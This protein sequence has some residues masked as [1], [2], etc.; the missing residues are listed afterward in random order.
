MTTTPTPE[1]VLALPLDPA[2]HEGRERTIR[3]YLIALLSTLWR[4]GSDFSS[5]RPLGMSDWQWEIYAVLVKAG[6][7]TG[8]FDKLGDLDDCD[9]R[10]ADDLIAGA[11]ASLIAF[12]APTPVEIT[13]TPQT[14]LR[15]LLAEIVEHDMDYVTRYPLV[16]RAVTFALD[17][18]Y[19]AGVRID[20]KE[21]D[22]PVVYIELPTG[23][24][25]WHMP[26]YANAFDGH[27][28]PEKFRRI[29]EY[30]ASPERE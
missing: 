3:D 6:L 18:G 2:R 30:I 27:S 19:V 12:V 16:F 13:L 20:P 14:V 11:I 7:I 24:V 5:K 9:H 22:Y 25:S 23:Q 28:T 17:C 8:T 29:R 4:E 10:A 1:Q 21:P 15:Q 26:Q